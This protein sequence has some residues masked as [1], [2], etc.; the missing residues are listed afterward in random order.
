MSQSSCL[1]WAQSFNAP[2]NQFMSALPDV[3]PNRF[4]VDSG[5]CF[6]MEMEMAPLNPL[7]PVCINVLLSAVSWLLEPREE[8]ALLV[9]LRP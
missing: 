8:P 2:T 1:F 7:Q 3:M 4:I 9:R 6:R 5:S